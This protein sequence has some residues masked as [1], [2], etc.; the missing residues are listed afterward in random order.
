MCCFTPA[1]DSSLFDQIVVWMTQLFPKYLGREFKHNAMKSSGG[2]KIKI[3]EN[4]F[5]RRDRTLWTGAGRSAGA[6][7]AATAFFPS[8]MSHPAH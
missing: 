7:R 3:Q 4:R 6:K 1:G 8:V 5:A 2:K